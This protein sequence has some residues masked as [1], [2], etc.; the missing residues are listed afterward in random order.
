MFVAKNRKI[1]AK[2]HFVVLKSRQT[3]KKT[4]LI[5]LA[6]THKRVVRYI[7]TEYEV[8][9]LYQFENGKIVCRKDAKLFNQRLDYVLSAYKDKLDQIP[10]QESYS[11]AQI[12]ELLER[13]EER[14]CNPGNITLI[15]CFQARIKEL[16]SEGRE[17]YADMNEETL[18]RIKNFLGEVTLV[19]INP[20]TIELFTKKMNGFSNATKQMS[21][22]H[23]KACINLEI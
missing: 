20:Y 16:R 21:L 23:I 4:Y 22:S 10:N 3:I 9:D 13:K 7:T 14:I 8:D 18:K 19:S 5:Y 11:C 15:E 12:K 1:M 2:L 6:I 17:S